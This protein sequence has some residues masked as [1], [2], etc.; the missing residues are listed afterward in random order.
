MVLRYDALD[1]VLRDATALDAVL[2]DATAVLREAVL[3]EAIA[4]DVDLLG[5]LYLVEATAEPPLRRFTG[6]VTLALYDG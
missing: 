4:L 2:R 5:A 1:A 3:R 6:A